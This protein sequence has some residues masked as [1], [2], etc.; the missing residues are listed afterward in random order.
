MFKVR[1]KL[2]MFEGDEQMFPCHFNYKIGDEFYYDG[3]SFT[4]R[5]CPGLLAPM[6]A[7]FLFQA[8]GERQLPPSPVR[9]ISPLPQTSSSPVGRSSRSLKIPP[10]TCGLSAI[11]ATRGAI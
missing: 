6:G 10:L 1:C 9:N 4:G 7:C 3:V 8:S 2:V 5:V 11:A